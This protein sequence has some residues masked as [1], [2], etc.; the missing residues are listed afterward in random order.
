MS[1]LQ[2]PGVRS[3]KPDG[4][5]RYHLA[6]WFVAFADGSGDWMAMVTRDDAGD[7]D[8]TY[9]FRYYE[10][11]VTNPLA[12]SKDRKSWM[13]AIVKASV[14]EAEIEEK[15][16]QMFGIILGLRGDPSCSGKIEFRTDD[17]DKIIPLLKAAPWVHVASI[18][19][20]G[21]KS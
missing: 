18:K 13:Q 4:T 17:M 9:R 6:Q 12:E 10:D 1:V 5:T 20:D 19:S 3:N 16:D 21:P 8:L 7:W 14:P 11:D 2:E 15:V